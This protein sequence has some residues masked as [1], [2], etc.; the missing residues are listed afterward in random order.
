MAR[1]IR[2]AAK[3]VREEA[4][5]EYCEV[6]RKTATE[7]HE[8]YVV[9]WERIV[10][11]PPDVLPLILKPVSEELKKH[12]HDEL[13]LFVSHRV[14][15]DHYKYYVQNGMDGLLDFYQGHYVATGTNYT[16]SF[17]KTCGDKVALT[18]YPPAGISYM[19]GLFLW[20]E[21]H[22]RQHKLLFPHRSQ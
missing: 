12:L 14:S 9:A 19:D 11:L 10:Q 8:K 5:P 22:A 20:D 7:F 18:D 2:C 3:Y 17:I 1:T 21:Y 6:W 4:V 16:R 15:R 13:R